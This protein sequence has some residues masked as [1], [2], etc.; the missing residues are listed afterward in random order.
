MATN[1]R[2][3]R[4]APVDIDRLRLANEKTIAIGN[5]KVN[6]RGDQLGPGGKII[7]TR[8]QVLAEKNKL[9]GAL[10]DDFEILDSLQSD[11]S[12][13]DFVVPATN[14]VQAVAQN[15]PVVENNYVK[16]RGSFAESV[17][18]ETEV[19]QELLD[20][21]EVINTPE[22]QPGIKRI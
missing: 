9:H 2:T 20:P 10:A 8:A 13:P 18:K 19:V 4:G 12:E 21:K 15:T 11:H 6:A 14:A 17:A 1:H 16:P 5:M 7:K 22:N 3:A